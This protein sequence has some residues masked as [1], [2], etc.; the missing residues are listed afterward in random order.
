MF[1]SEDYVSYFDDIRQIE[2]KMLVRARTLKKY[3]GS[4]EK[5]AKLIDHWYKDETKHKKICG[6]IINMIRSK[7]SS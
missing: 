3:F 2:S 5:A 7:Y 1:T 4:D 6:R